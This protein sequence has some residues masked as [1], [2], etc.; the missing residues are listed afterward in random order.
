LLFSVVVFILA[1]NP[2]QAG[3]SKDLV[4]DEPVMEE[5]KF[6]EG[7]EGKDVD[8]EVW[9]KVVI[10]DG[11]DSC[12]QPN[13]AIDSE[14]LPYI[15]YSCSSPQMMKVAHPVVLGSYDNW[16]IQNVDTIDVD[17]QTSIV[18]GHSGLPIV[19]YG[20]FEDFVDYLLKW[21]ERVEP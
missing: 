9:S 19:T 10:E 14:G 11:S 16:E 4:G 7:E 13:I 15:S 17:W 5:A 6:V 12:S 21:A 8:G 1:L 3:N 2:V 18:I 20:G